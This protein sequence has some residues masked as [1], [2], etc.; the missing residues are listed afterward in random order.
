MVAAFHCGSDLGGETECSPPGASR[1][2]SKH[3][4]LTTPLSSAPLPTLIKV[5]PC[6]LPCLD[7]LH[8]SVEAR[9]CRLEMF[10]C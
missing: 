4:Y 9:L 10:L 5:L 2:R 7:A 1:I 3:D 6:W 8:A